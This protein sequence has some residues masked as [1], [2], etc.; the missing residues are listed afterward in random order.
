ME[1]VRAFGPSSWKPQEKV[2][3]GE[4][5]KTLSWSSPL[6]CK[7]VVMVCHGEA[8]EQIWKESSGRMTR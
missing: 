3:S 4:R 2:V 7:P 8:L 1:K 5:R 6:M